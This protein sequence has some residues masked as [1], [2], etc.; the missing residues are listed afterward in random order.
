MHRRST[1]D[2][3]IRVRKPHSVIIRWM[4]ESS[5]KISPFSWKGHKSLELS[6]KIL[7]FGSTKGSKTGVINFQFKRQGFLYGVLMS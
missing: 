1:Q 5:P 4:G 7:T 6:F 3:Q 2:A